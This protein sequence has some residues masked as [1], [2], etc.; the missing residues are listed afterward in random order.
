M[1][2]FTAKNPQ[3]LCLYNDLSTLKKWKHCEPQGLATIYGAQ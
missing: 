1:M 2:Q 3:S